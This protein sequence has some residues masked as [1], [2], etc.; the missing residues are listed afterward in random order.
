M[1]PELLI[2][3]IKSGLF[4]NRVT[5]SRESG[6][7]LKPL[8]T[9][10]S[11]AISVFHYFVFRLPPITQIVYRGLSLP[12]PHPPSFTHPIPFS[13]S[14]SLPFVR[15]WIYDRTHP[16]ILEI[17]LFQNHAYIIPDDDEHEVLLPSGTLVPF[18]SRIDHH[19]AI[20][21]CRFD[22]LVK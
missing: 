16:V 7:Q 5:Y 20:I 2:C 14:T 9:R 17:H 22:K 6:V 12:S 15:N 19:V 1:L 8:D 21:S 13:A 3:S 18:Q 11:R 10:C 4:T